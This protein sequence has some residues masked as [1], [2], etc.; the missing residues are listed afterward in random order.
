MPDALVGRGEGAQ[1][2]EEAK[3]VEGFEF[4]IFLFI[5][6]GMSADVTPPF[7]FFRISSCMVP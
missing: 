2:E 6:D 1:A 3:C 7:Y 4:H 5:D